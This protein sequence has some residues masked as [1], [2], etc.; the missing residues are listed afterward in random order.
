MNLNNLKTTAAAAPAAATT[1]EIPETNVD[2]KKPEGET[3]D[4]ELNQN[5]PQ[6]E[7][8]SEGA[9]QAES[10]AE[11]TGVTYPHLYHSSIPNLGIGRFQF[12]KGALK[13]ETDA[14]AAEFDTLLSGIDSFTSSKVRKLDPQAAEAIVR[15]HLESKASRVADSATTAGFENLQ[16]PVGTTELGAEDKQ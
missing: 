1:Q 15:Q 4:G 6:T 9:T 2:L 10:A 7:G 11:P 3:G 16:P 8:P 13:F 12:E 14:E 5:P